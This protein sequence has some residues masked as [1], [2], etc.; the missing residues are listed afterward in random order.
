M[1]ARSLRGAL[2]TLRRR[3]ALRVLTAVWALQIICFVYLITY[4]VYRS[5]PG[6][7]P[8]ELRQLLTS[9]LPASADRTVVG[10]LPMWGGPVMLILGALVAGGDERWGSSRTVLARFADRTAFLL[11]RFLALVLVLLLLSVLTIALSALCSAAIAAAEGEAIRWPGPGRLAVALVSVWL[12]VTAW[13]AVGFT[14]ALATRNL[15]AAIGIG[16]LWTL[17]VENLVNGLGAVIPLFG[18]VGSILLSTS[19]GS[20]AAA[21]G[22]SGFGV[23]PVTSGPVAAAVLAGYTVV[24]LTTALVIFRRRDLG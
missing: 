15:A 12:I 13:G 22:A 17:M 1:T 23:D 20:V 16:L 18:A 5:V 8:D 21:L 6:E 2:F 14:L 10:A 19:S 24:A 9:L 4:I 7:S 3:P 11:G